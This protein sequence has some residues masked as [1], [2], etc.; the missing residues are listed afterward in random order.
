MISKQTIAFH[1]DVRMLRQ[2]SML[3]LQAQRSRVGPQY[4]CSPVI[5]VS[6]YTAGMMSVSPRFLL[7][8]IRLRAGGLYDTFKLVSGILDLQLLLQITKQQ[9]SVE[10]YPLGQHSLLQQSTTKGLQ[11]RPRVV[12]IM[13]PC[14]PLGLPCTAHG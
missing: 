6:F 8:N 13:M 5:T 4:D 3:K 12:E 14:V 2:Y 9:T 7:R 1:S 10:N 11:L